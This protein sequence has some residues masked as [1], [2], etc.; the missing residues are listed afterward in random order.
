MA[1][2]CYKKSDDFSS[3]LLIYSSLGLKNKLLEIAEKAE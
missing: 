2:E 1:I 3:L